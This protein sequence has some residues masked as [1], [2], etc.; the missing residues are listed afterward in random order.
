MDKL[1]EYD[2]IVPKTGEPTAQLVAW[3]GQRGGLTIEKMAFDQSQSP[4]YDFLKTVQPEAGVSYVLVNALGSYEFYDDNRNG[5]GFPA[6]PFN[7]GKRALCGHPECTGSLDGWVSEPETLLHHYK[8]FEQ[9]GG[10]YK[11]HVNKDPSKSLG[12]VKHAFWNDRMK[13]VELL[14]RVVD[15]RDAQ[16][17]RRIGDGDFPAVS[18]GCHVRWDV[19]TICGHRAPTR[20]QYCEHALNLLRSILADGR[21][22][23]VLNPSPRFFDISFVFKPADETGWTLQKVAHEFFR[24]SALFGETMALHGAERDVFMKVAAEMRAGW[25]TPY[26]L[27]GGFVQSAAPSLASREKVA[28][29]ASVAE[30][31]T[32]MPQGAVIHAIAEEQGLKL[33]EHVVDR[34]VLATPAI[35]AVL[36]RHAGTLK[37]A[38]YGPTGDVLRDRAYS[39]WSDFPVAHMGPGA[40]Y[41]ASEPPRTDMLTITDPYTGSV[42]QTTRGTA[43]AASRGDVKTRLSHAA[44]LSALYAAGIHR[45]VGRTPSWKRTAIL[46]PIAAGLGFGTER[47]LHDAFAPTRNPVYLTDQGV[48]VSGATEFKGAEVTPADWAEKL[49]HDLVERVGAADHDALVRRVSAESPRFAKW[50]ALPL[51]SQID[52]LTLDAEDDSDPAAVPTLDLLAFGENV[53]NLLTT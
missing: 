44:V 27:I 38:S 16:I 2:A 51:E 5:D 50:A 33:S 41:R 26:S 20:A 25:S 14:L 13:R 15:E 28:S 18:M 46:S 17:A 34:L 49:A 29:V 35:V 24:H 12:D 53:W 48:P 39:P 11:H 9:F 21:R 30:A 4:A 52:A 8:T 36:G 10:I 19:C 37:T 42:Y 45:F 23:C 43:M 22:V 31:A 6:R 47:L 3:T 32:P 7:V 40:A 1:L